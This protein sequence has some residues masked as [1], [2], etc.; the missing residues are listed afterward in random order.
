MD[1]LMVNK[2]WTLYTQGLRLQMEY[3]I[4]VEQEPTN[5]HISILNEIREN[6]TKLY[7]FIKKNK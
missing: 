5:S 2:A 3:E 4:K 6:N 1:N 7:D